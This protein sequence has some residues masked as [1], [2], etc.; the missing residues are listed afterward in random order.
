MLSY[1]L[2]YVFSGYLVIYWG[3][4][5]GGSFIWNEGIVPIFALIG[6][7]AKSDAVKIFWGTLGVC[8]LAYPAV[9]VRRVLML[10][11]LGEKVILLGAA[12]DN[13]LKILDEANESTYPATSLD[14]GRMAFVFGDTE[15]A[16]L[17]KYFEPNLARMVIR[18]VSAVDMIAAATSSPHVNA[19]IAR[20]C[21]QVRT[22]LEAFHL[23]A[24][25]EKLR[26]AQE[27]PSEA[28]AAARLAR[29]DQ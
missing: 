4:Y 19:E 6:P 5:R 16:L 26:L 7:S 21:T 11:T 1:L 17:A 10:R 9:H 15:D 3:L 25:L 18:T 23:P 12:R 22:E 27:R 13:I 14:G 20:I 2:L 24:F 28:A 8:A 29:A